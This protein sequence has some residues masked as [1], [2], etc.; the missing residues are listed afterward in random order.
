MKPWDS[1]ID[2]RDSII[3]INIQKIL[4]CDMKKKDA[5]NSPLEN[6]K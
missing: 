5:D 4:I 6:E 1:Q 2:F 3:R